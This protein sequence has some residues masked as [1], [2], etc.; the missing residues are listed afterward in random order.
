MDKQLFDDGDLENLLAELEDSRI[1][2]EEDPEMEASQRRY[3]E[4]IKKHKE[5]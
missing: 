1:D 5:D 4:I 3:M 2:G